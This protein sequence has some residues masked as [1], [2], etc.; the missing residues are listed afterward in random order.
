MATKRCFKCGIGILTTES[1]DGIPQ[2]RCE[3]CGALTF[4]ECSAAPLALR[5][6]SS[7]SHFSPLFAQALPRFPQTLRVH[8]LLVWLRRND[9]EAWTLERLLAALDEAGY[10]HYKVP[11]KWTLM[12]SRQQAARQARELVGAA[13]G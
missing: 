10:R 9:I 11:P 12:A 2:V 8:R 3:N 7:D 5:R 13:A 4:L 1:I 6:V